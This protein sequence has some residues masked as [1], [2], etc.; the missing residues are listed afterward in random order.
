M[1]L[2]SGQLAIEQHQSTDPIAALGVS[3]GCDMEEKLVGVGSLLEVL[4]A[5]RGSRVGDQ[6]VG[7]VRVQLVGIEGLLARLVYSAL[8]VIYLAGAAEGER[9]FWIKGRGGLEFACGQLYVA[10]A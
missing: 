7:F 2:Y 10:R 9:F 3:P 1:N 8:A 5:R 6:E 4:G